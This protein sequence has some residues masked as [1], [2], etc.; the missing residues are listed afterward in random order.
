MTTNEYDA[1]VVG[2][3]PNG[4]TAAITMARAGKRVVLFEANA[5]PRRRL[6]H[7]GAHRARLPPRRLLVGASHRRRRRPRSPTLPL[8]EHG[9]EWCHPEIALAHPLDGGRAGLLHRS[10]RRHRGGPRPTTAPRTARSCVRTSPRPQ[11]ITETIY[12]RR[13]ASRTR[14]S[15]WPRFGLVVDRFRRAP[16][17]APLHR[18]TKAAPSSRGSAAHS[19]VPLNQPATAGYGL[20]LTSLGTPWAGRSRPAAR[21]RITDALVAILR[22]H[23]GEVVTDHRVTSLAELPAGC[24]SPC[25]TSP[26]ASSSRI[27]GDDIPARYQPHAAPL[28]VR[29]RRL[30]DRLGALRA[31]AVDQPRRPAGRHR[32]PRRHHRGDRRGRGGGRRAAKCP[33][34]R[35]CSSCSPPSPT[36]PAHPTASTSAGPTATC[37]TAPPSTAPRRSRRRSSGSPP[38]SATRSSPATR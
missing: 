5:D 16:H 19:M 23:G 27:G 38:D 25:S 4:L 22:A 11:T 35:S 9:V 3:G 31:G 12:S 21:N 26:R 32:A 20:F 36:R 24:E 28:P 8:A 14:R 33:T 29:A 15:R 7:R 37:P 13:S 30:Q 1:V 34:G 6:S 17:Q 18:P 10:R 2:A